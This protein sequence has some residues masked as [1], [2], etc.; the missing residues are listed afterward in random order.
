MKGNEN[1]DC[2]I[3]LNMRYEVG[4]SCDGDAKQSSAAGETVYYKRCNQY[5]LYYFMKQFYAHIFYD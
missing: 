4:T 3:F 5:T 2:D 1:I